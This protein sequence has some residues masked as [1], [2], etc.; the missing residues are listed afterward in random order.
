MIYKNPR[1][2]TFQQQHQHAKVSQKQ[3]G[4]A[5]KIL[6]RQRRSRFIIGSQ[7]YKR[8]CRLPPWWTTSR[9]LLSKPP[10]TSTSCILRAS[11]SS[12]T[13]NT[14]PSSASYS[15]SS[16]TY[17]HGPRNSTN[18]AAYSHPR[19]RARH[20]SSSLLHPS[21]ETL[22]LPATVTRPTRG[23]RRE[24]N[25]GG[26]VQITGRSMDQRCSNTTTA[27]CTDVLHGLRLLP[28][29]SSGA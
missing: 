22:C 14:T 19:S 2:K 5:G 21:R 29:I 12:A 8:K 4:Q 3:D 20:R 16:S 24:P 27:A 10:S 17:H 25:S 6:R 18:S 26:Y 28:Q 9:K 15:S 1:N 23:H 11:A 13:R 7:S